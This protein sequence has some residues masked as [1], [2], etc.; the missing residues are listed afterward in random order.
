MLFCTLGRLSLAI[1][2][3]SNL[4]SASTNSNQCRTSIDYEWPSQFVR[5]GEASI[6]VLVQGHGP[7]VLIIP[8]FGRDAGSDFNYFSNA[9]VQAGYKVLRP[10]PRGALGSVGPMQNVTV[11]ELTGEIAAII[12]VLASSRA[13]VL[14][15]AYGQFIGK[16]TAYLY[17]EKI[18]AVIA[19]SAGA[20]DNIPADI[21]NAPFVAANVSLPASTRLAALQ[22][23]FFA[24]GHDAHIWLQ[25]WHPSTLAME[26]A[27][28]KSAGPGGTGQHLCGASET[29]ILDLIP[30]EDVFRPKETWNQTVDTCPDRAVLEIVQ[31]AGHALFPEQPDVVVEKV[32]PWLKQQSSRL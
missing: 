19:A 2:A 4:A 11:A 27:V 31:D 16:A 28:V 8:S 32:L 3:F 18:P 5:Y 26:A 17:P 21:N 25:G 24:P 23:A 12:D 7:A 10:Q 14:G 30:A 22:K 29:Q 9:L 20:L 13:I 6:R 15:H 1:A